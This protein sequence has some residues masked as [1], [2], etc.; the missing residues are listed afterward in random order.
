MLYSFL[1]LIE[2]P[3]NHRFIMI[4]TEHRVDRVLIGK[5]NKS[6]RCT[7]NLSP[8]VTLCLPV[9]T[10]KSFNIDGFW[11]KL[12]HLSFTSLRKA[13]L[14]FATWEHHTLRT[15]RSW[16]LTASI[17]SSTWCYLDLYISWCSWLIVRLSIKA[18]AVLWDGR[19]EWRN[20]L[21]KCSNTNEGAVSAAC[22]SSAIS[23]RCTVK[24]REVI[25]C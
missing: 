14:K 17:D 5:L 9:E 19:T 25:A 24:E 8:S 4:P 21:P 23:W 12:H 18:P 6:A 13:P 1:A 16:T 10:T 7:W 22:T 3:R 15:C 20:A 11:S 2:I